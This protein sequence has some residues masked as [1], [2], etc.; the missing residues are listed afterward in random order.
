MFAHRVM[1]A[2]FYGDPAMFTRYLAQ[3]KGNFLRFYWDKL[4]ERIEK[5]E[6]RVDPTGLSGE[7]RILDK[8]VQA[9]LIIMPLP[10]KVAEA[11]FVVTLYHPE[12]KGAPLARYYTLEL[13]NN[14]LTQQDY[15][16]FCQWTADQAHGNMGEGPEPQIDAFLATVEATL[17]G[18]A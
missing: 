3:D 9:G 12:F 8:N 1:P 10:E 4:T 15:T 18:S 7:V 16:V 6:E 14:F 17:E 2:I 11:Y 5:P 13:G